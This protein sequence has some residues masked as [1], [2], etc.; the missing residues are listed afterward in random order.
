MSELLECDTV[1]APHDQTLH[2]LLLGCSGVSCQLNS[3]STDLIPPTA[4]HLTWDR[5]P[6]IYAALTR[7]VTPSASYDAFVLDPEVITQ[8]VLAAIPLLRQYLHLPVWVVDDGPKSPAL[9]K[10]ILAGA[11]R[12]T[13]AL[14]QR[15]KTRP[16]VLEEAPQTDLSA[17]APPLPNPLD[18]NSQK[19]I[20]APAPERNNLKPSAGIPADSLKIPHASHNP[21]SKAAPKP[22]DIAEP[23]ISAEEMRALLGP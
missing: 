16:A 5:T 10:A 1:S 18:G 21:I 12:L 8:A 15:I 14:A 2:L 3:S 20:H 9:D 19:E 6:D 22:Y 17:I 11:T 4:P 7:L 13:E 23:L